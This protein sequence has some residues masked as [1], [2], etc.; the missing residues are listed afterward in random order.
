[1]AVQLKNENDLPS[2]Q[3]QQC[4]FSS[5]F[6]IKLFFKSNSMKYILLKISKTNH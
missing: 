4:V 6:F 3:D 1:M 5:I 2:F